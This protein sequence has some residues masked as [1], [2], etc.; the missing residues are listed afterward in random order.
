MLDFLIKPWLSN[1]HQSG[2]ESLVSSTTFSVEKSAVVEGSF[3]FH[4]CLWSLN[5]RTSCSNILESAISLEFH[6]LSKS[7]F[8]E[9]CR[10]E[11]FHQFTIKS[12]CFFFINLSVKSRV[13]LSR[14]IRLSRRKIRFQ[15]LSCGVLWFEISNSSVYLDILADSSLSLWIISCIKD[16]VASSTFETKDS[17]E[18]L[19]LKIFPIKLSPTVWVLEDY[20]HSNLNI[21]RKT[22]SLFQLRYPSTTLN[23]WTSNV[24]LGNLF[25]HC[26]NVL[27]IIAIKSWYLIEQNFLRVLRIL[28][29]NS[30]QIHCSQFFAG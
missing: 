7:F 11:I 22:V 12:F 29:E 3:N 9:V 8:F 20:R 4:H 17:L 23:S 1:F 27:T 28:V 16:W 13:N 2:L 18:T 19:F 15:K 30:T 21:S 10:Y 25:H 6:R 5:Q 24:F 14:R 26:H